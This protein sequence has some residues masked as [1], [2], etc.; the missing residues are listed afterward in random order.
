[1]QKLY[2][3]SRQEYENTEILTTASTLTVAKKMVESA[4]ANEGLPE[5][6]SNYTITELINNI[7]TGKRWDYYCSYSYEKEWRKP[8]MAKWKWKREI[9]YDSKN[10]SYNWV[11]HFY[12]WVKHYK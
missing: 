10:H 5:Y 12:T 1:M 9:D 4:V 7:N 2:I 6:W 11:N 3:I 8:K